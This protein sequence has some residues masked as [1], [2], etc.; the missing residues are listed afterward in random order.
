[1][2]LINEKTKESEEIWK[3]LPYPERSDFCYGMTQFAI[4]M[5]YIR[6]DLEG[7]LPHTDTRLRPDQRALENGDLKLAG[8]EKNRVEEL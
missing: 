3:K 1:M 8:A 4:Q 5:N 6:P 2:K 7:V